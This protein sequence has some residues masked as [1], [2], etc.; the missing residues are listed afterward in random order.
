MNVITIIKNELK[1]MIRNRVNFIILLVMPIAMIALMGYALKPFFTAGEKGIEKFNLLYVNNDNGYIGKSIDEFIKGEGSR[2][3]NLVKP[4]SEDIEGQLL[5]RN[6]DEAIVIPEGLTDKLAGGKEASIMHISSGKNIISNNVVKSFLVNFKD[7]ANIGMSIENIIKEYDLNTFEAASIKADLARKYGTSFVNTKELNKQEASKLGSFQYFSVSMLIFF[8]LTSGM[9][10]GIGIVDDRTDR[11]Y[12]RINSYP[13]TSNQYLFGKALG[14]GVIGILQAAMIIVFTSLVFKVNWGNNYAGIAV[15][16]TAVLFSSSGLAVIL[17]S[18]LNS[19][20]ALSTALIVIYWS[21]T[22]ISGAFAP[23][24]AFEPIGRFTM[25]KW[26]FEAIASFMAGKGFV[27]AVNYLLMLIG[28][29]LI[30]WMIGI[31]LY[32]R[33]AANE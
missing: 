26:A 20:K 6:M 30:L 31:I 1:L 22:F 14:N 18:F 32:K 2:Y 19:S 15:V 4:D 16:V 3:F 25:N 23:V 27:Y 5:S 13:V 8:L 33:R 10:L 7:T 28:L 21:I 12:S 9:G 29:C 11:L 24:P 17:S